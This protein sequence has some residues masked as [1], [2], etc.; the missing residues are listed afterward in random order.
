[1][2]DNENP[3]PL[4]IS[5]SKALFEQDSIAYIDRLDEY[6]LETEE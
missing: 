4:N 5:Y 6:S 3:M 2:L 1:M